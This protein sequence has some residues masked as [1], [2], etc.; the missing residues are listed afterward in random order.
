MEATSSPNRR[1]QRGTII[2]PVLVP[3]FA[4]GGAGLGEEG[5]VDAAGIL[6]GQNVCDVGDVVEKFS[7]AHSS[8]SI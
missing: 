8:L 3:A 4:T 6:V 2:S 1:W 5:I 7:S